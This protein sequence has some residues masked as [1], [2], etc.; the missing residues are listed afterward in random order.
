[1]LRCVKKNKNKPLFRLIIG[2]EYYYKLVDITNHIG[3]NVFN[4]SSKRCS[5]ITDPDINKLIKQTRRYEYL[6]GLRDIQLALIFGISGFAIWLA[7]E[8]FW[9]KWIVK[10]IIAYGHL[11]GWITM[12]PIILLVIIVIAMLPIMKFLRQHWLWRET[13]MV[14]TSRASIPA[15]V[16]VVSIIIF[17][18]CLMISLD[19]KYIGK[20]ND[21]FILR[22][23]LA[24][25][26]WAFGY[27]LLG[28]GRF[29]G[30]PRYVWL[31][32]IGGLLSTLVLVAHLPFSQSSLIFGFGWCLLLAASGV[33]NL[34][35]VST[36]VKSGEQWKTITKI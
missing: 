19:L 22:I 27:I 18:I 6:D 23:L 25:T 11:A 4:N 1:M 32:V 21:I 9:I 5:M 15:H 16:N 3:Y 12:L 20:V 17:L 7:F 30:L 28:M 8:P 33:F 26:G 36:A 24:A 10:T 14:Q 31:G 34:W 35:R 13:G 29:I 2:V